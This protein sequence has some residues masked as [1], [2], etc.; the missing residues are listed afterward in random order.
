MT[1]TKS[2]FFVFCFMFSPL[3][4][5]KLFSASTL[6][7]CSCSCSRFYFRLAWTYVTQAQRRRRKAWLPARSAP[8]RREEWT[9]TST[10]SCETAAASSPWQKGTG[11]CF[12]CACVCHEST[13]QYMHDKRDQEVQFLF[14][15]VE[16]K[17][18]CTSRA[19]PCDDS[20]RGIQPVLCV[21]LY[22]NFDRKWL[23]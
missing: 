10:V 9:V 22:P 23:R 21:C 3:S 6:L 20:R 15:S 18:P 16:A 14:F 8:P 12:V 5:R 7:R 11:G 4:A 1:K 17:V 19:L 13:L 2:C